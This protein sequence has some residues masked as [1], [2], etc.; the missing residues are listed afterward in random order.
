LIIREFDSDFD[1]NL[2]AVIVLH[3]GFA[4]ESGGNDCFGT[5]PQ[6]RIQSIARSARPGLWTASGPFVIGLNAF[7]IASAL[8]GTCDEDI[9]RI[10]VV[11]RYILCTRF[12]AE[13][14]VNA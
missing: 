9:A 6:N 14:G 1:G 2:D 8:R 13:L 7:M 11:S 10:G 5:T 4:A 12:Q 3:S